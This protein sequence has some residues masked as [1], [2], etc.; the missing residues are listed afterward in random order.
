MGRKKDWEAY[1][2]LPHL[3]GALRE[4][5]EARR[6]HRQVRYLLFCLKNAA[7]Q[8]FK[9]EGSASYPPGF[10]EFWLAERPLY[11]IDSLNNRVSVPPDKARRVMELGGY[12]EFAK[13]WD[14]D[15]DL[16]VYIRHASVWQEWNAKL[17]RIVPVLGE[18]E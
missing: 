18:G 5:M 12:K 6:R 15:E 1:P 14:V 11:A 10:I 2:D 4:K 7:D 8:G 3:R 17:M 16:M 13:R 9:L